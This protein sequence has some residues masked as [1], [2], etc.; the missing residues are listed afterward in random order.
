MGAKQARKA[1]FNS[2]PPARVIF[3]RLVGRIF[4][5]VTATRAT[6][7]PREKRAAFVRFFIYAGIMSH[8]IPQAANRVV[9][10]IGLSRRAAD[11]VVGA[12]LLVSRLDC[13]PQQ[14]ADLRRHPIREW[15]NLLHMDG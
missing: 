14:R 12:E 1:G 9:G 5:R 3:D 10:G 15:S 6:T 11:R 13:A 2:T 4:V 7:T 8:E